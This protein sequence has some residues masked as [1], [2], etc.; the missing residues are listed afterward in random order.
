MNLE[1]MPVYLASLTV[2]RRLSAIGQEMNVWSISD[3]P[4]RGS[5]AW[6]AV[7]YFTEMPG[8]CHQDQ[9][10]CC[11]SSQGHSQVRPK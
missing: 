9:D 3:L 1:T 2:K 8:G 10:M 5:A 7:T 4:T 11:A 6:F